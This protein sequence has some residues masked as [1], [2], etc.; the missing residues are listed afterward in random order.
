MKDCKCHKGKP[1]CYKISLHPETELNVG[2]YKDDILGNL[3]LL[4]YYMNDLSLD[5]VIVMGTNIKHLGEC[6][7]KNRMSYEKD[8]HQS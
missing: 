5:E 3:F 4:K 6:I 2:N 8:I 1:M 7:I